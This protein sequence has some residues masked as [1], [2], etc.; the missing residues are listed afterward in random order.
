[1]LRTNIAVVIF[2]SSIFFH[3]IFPFFISIGYLPVG[4]AILSFS[5][6]VVPTH[7]HS[8]GLSRPLTFLWLSPY[9]VRTIGFILPR[10]TS[11][12]LTTLLSAC[13]Q[14]FYEFD[15]ARIE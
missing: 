14:E 11:V 2:W 8:R 10:F 7:I 15:L 1:M 4:L 5:W 6:L 3:F 13:V 12:T 9:Y